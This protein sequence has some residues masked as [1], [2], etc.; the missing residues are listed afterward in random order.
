MSTDFILFPLGVNI[1]HR[2]KFL[3]YKEP[4]GNVGWRA[5]CHPRHS[6]VNSRDYD[7]I[8]AADGKK[9]TLNFKKKE[10]RAKLAIG[11]SFNFVNGNTARE[12]EVTEVSGISYTYHQDWFKKL[13]KEH[14][15]ELENIV[16]YKVT[17]T[18]F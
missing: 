9:Y 10:F 17:H 5:E 3:G 18:L 13:S 2:T 11:I 16:Y 15:I 6:V 1:Y 12:N 14:G 4:T 8:L 7:V